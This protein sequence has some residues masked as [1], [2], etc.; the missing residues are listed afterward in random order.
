M[1]TSRVR[2]LVAAGHD[3]AWSP[4]GR[5]LLYVQGG[6]SSNS[7]AIST[8]DVQTVTPSGHVSTVVYG[9]KAYGGQIVSA[10]WVT[11]ARGVRYPAPQQVDGVFAGGPVQE[12]VADGGRAAFVACGG[13]SAWTPATG[14]SVV[15]K[16]LSAPRKRV[17]SVL[18]CDR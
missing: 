2:A 11:P 7:D 5:K 3:I 12:L 17:S 16:P 1:R 9:S 14:E 15:K 4:D 6:E 8:G 18:G 10:A 13:V